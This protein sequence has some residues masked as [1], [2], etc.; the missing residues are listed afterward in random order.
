MIDENNGDKKK[1]KKKN[2]KKKKKPKTNNFVEDENPDSDND[3]FTPL[4]DQ[5]DDSFFED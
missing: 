5:L 3:S 2:K 1:R 4:K